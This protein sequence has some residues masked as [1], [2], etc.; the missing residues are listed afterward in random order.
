M[1]TNAKTSDKDDA[2][3][4]DLNEDCVAPEKEVVLKDGLY[5]V[6]PGERAMVA[7][8]RYLEHIPKEDQE[9]KMHELCFE[10]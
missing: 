10:S 4:I 9:L 6:D 5:P 3:L 8:G 2:P 1:A 7:I